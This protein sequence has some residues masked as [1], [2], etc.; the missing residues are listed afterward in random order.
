MPATTTE[1]RDNPTTAAVTE[2]NR[3]FAEA[4][5]RGIE[6]SKAAFEVARDLLD[7]A[8]EVNKKVFEAWLATSESSLKASFE[9]YNASLSLALPLLEATTNSSRA[10]LQQWDVV[11]RQGQKA[12]LEVFHAQV[13]AA[14]RYARTSA[15]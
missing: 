13:R 15:R 7:D 9:V 5:R 3:V 8:T 10:L 6:E 1:S 11:A 12:A 14:A 2:A 4:S